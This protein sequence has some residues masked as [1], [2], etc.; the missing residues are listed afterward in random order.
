VHPGSGVTAEHMQMTLVLICTRL[1]HYRAPDAD[2]ERN[3]SAIANLSF[4]FNSNHGSTTFTV[5][6]KCKWNTNK[7]KNVTNKSALKA[8]LTRD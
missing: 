7:L 2:A 3:L 5:P 8:Q 6:A 1:V 4:L